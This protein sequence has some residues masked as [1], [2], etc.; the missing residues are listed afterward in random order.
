MNDLLMHMGGEVE[1]MDE[2]EACIAD[3]SSCPVAHKCLTNPNVL[4]CPKTPADELTKEA[5]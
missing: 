4:R 2:L 3:C 5:S 1:D